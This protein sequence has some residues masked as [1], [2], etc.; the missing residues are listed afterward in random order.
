MFITG[1]M[2]IDYNIKTY[3]C[4]VLIKVDFTDITVYFSICVAAVMLFNVLKKTDMAEDTKKNSFIIS[5]RD[6]IFIGTLLVGM[7]SSYVLVQARIST[8][9]K[10]VNTNSEQLK[11]NNLELLKYKM[12]ELKRSQD[13]M[14]TTLNKFIDD[15]YSGQHGSR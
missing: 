4:Q 1:T 2:Y 15:Y 14:A 9:E 5:W 8:L 11:S 6:A 3:L 10:E 13:D 7:A 12:D